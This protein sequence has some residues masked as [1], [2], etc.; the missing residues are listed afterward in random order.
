MYHNV[1]KIYHFL[2]NVMKN[3]KKVIGMIVDGAQDKRD[4]LLIS[5]LFDAVF[6]IE[7]TESKVL[8]VP[9]LH[10]SNRSFKIKYSDGIVEII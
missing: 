4:E 3:T 2:L 7:R 5:T 10:M 8:L 9:E 6:R 1:G